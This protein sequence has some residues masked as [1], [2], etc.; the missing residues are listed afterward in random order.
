MPRRILK[1]FIPTRCAQCL[2]HVKDPVIG[3]YNR[4]YCEHCG[5]PFCKEIKEH[6]RTMGASNRMRNIDAF[7]VSPERILAFRLKHLR[8]QLGATRE[9]INML[10]EILGRRTG[11]PRLQLLRWSGLEEYRPRRGD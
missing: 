10:T 8:N 11:P 7:Q 1:P 5:T 3:R 2:L 4:L 6:L 9:E